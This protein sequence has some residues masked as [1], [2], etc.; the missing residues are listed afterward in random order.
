PPSAK[1]LRAAGLP[2]DTAAFRVDYLV[3][4][5]ENK[6]LGG[7]AYRAG[8]R[9]G[10]LVLKVDGREFESGDH[11]H[12]WFRLTRKIGEKVPVEIVRGGKRKTV[13]LTVAEGQRY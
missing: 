13:E 7:N 9:Q 10:D 6:H 8:L 5:G 2:A 4:W 11:F 1:Q 3:T 12:A